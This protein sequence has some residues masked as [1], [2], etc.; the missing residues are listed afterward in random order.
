M[1]IILNLSQLRGSITEARANISELQTQLDTLLGLKRSAIEAMRPRVLRIRG[2]YTM[3]NDAWGE[4]AEAL[5]EK[6]RAF[7]LEI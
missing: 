3:L 1:E 5:A 2:L 7:S 6:V 4:T